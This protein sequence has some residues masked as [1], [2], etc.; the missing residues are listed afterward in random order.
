MLACVPIAEEQSWAHRISKRDIRA[1]P[2]ADMVEETLKLLKRRSP[3]EESK[4]KPRRVTE[5]MRRGVMTFMERQVMA[6]ALR[7]PGESAKSI[8]P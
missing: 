1:Q 3:D 2:G 7:S 4:D 8:A 6:D 5:M